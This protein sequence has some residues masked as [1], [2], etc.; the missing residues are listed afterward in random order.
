M[1]Y[2]VS[3]GTLNLTIPIVLTPVLYKY[4]LMYLVKYID[5][6]GVS[7]IA[8]RRLTAKGSL[9]QSVVNLKV[10]RIWLELGE[11]A[12]WISDSSYR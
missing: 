1:T 10:Y 8:N 4:L 12:C 6:V 2:N 3:S 7:V 5:V 11:A 9:V